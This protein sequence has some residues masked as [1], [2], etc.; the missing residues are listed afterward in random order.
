MSQFDV[1]AWPRW[2]GYLALALV[3]LGNAAGNILLKIGANAA[4]SNNLLFGVLPWQTF[5]GIAC[6]GL[7]VLIYS[8]ALGQFEL[9]AA[10]IVISLQYVVVIGLAAF[11]LGE[12]I[13]TQTWLGIGFIA[14]GLLLCSQ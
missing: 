12:T 4:K 5:A 8:W 10:Q 2:A 13:S 11:F 7:G 3:I 6:F 14:V 1:S 9:H